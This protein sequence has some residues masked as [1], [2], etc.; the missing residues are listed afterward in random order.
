MKIFSLQGDTVDALCWRY[1]E[2][3]QSMVEQ[4]LVANPGLAD[5]GVILPTG[6]PLEL[7]DITAAA[8]CET[9]QLWD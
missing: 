4:V 6:T 3:T 8:V 1:Y 7:P 9:Y 5:L 2:R